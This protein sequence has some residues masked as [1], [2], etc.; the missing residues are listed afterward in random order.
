MNRRILFI[1]AAAL[2]LI[3]CSK[4]SGKPGPGMM[5]MTLAYAAIPDVSLV[6]AALARGFFEAEG[7]RVR[8]KPFGFGKLALAAVLAG[9]ADLATVAETP[10]AFSILEG[11]DIRIAAVI[12]ASD[13]NAAIVAKR[14][15]GIAKPE[16]IA[17]KSIGVTRG[18]TGEYFLHCFL[19]AQGMTEKDVAILDLRPE[20]MIGALAGGKIA[21][22]ATWNP[23]LQRIGSALADDGVFL[24][25]DNVYTE[26]FCAA[27]TRGFVDGN[28][29]A[30]KAFMRALL[31]AEDFIEGDPGA[32]IALVARYDNSDA[33][34]LAEVFGLF[35]FKLS[36]DQSL[37]IILEDEARWALRTQGSGPG[38]GGRGMPNFLGYLYADALAK[39]AP[40]R[41]RIIR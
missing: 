6:H 28:P 37:L 1:V 36:L 17:G 25:G 21:A 4:G 23:T 24:Y 13:R 29:E 35:R 16:D 27:G 2:P 11:A 19:I 31:R 20:D 15:A 7:L 41:V 34:S 9:E 40:E 8:A 5:D 38:D 39:V 22:A 26:N 32:A 33:A 18:T 3:A 30:M 10:L 12:A 14:S